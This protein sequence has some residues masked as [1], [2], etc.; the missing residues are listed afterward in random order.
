MPN[1]VSFAGPGFAQQVF[2]NSMLPGFDVAPIL[3]EK[4]GCKISNGSF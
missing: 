3:E 1:C 2:H 4:G